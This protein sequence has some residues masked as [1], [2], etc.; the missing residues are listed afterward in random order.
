MQRV[1]NESSAA[2]TKDH[3]KK[4]KLIKKVNVTK[5]MWNDLSDMTSR[6]KRLE[7]QTELEAVKVNRVTF[8]EHDESDH[9][10]KEYH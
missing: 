8:R 7:R 6:G 9:E 3:N 4:N 1:T 2:N 5:T 10:S